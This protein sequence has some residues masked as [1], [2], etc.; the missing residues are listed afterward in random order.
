M[1]AGA[2]FD[3]R[4]R[5]PA[6]A[7]PTLVVTGEEDALIPVINGEAIALLI[8]GARYACL[9]GSGH[10]LAVERPAE[11]ALLLDELLAENRDGNDCNGVA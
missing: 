5:L 3:V 9:P 6:L 1:R 10:M 11:L 7:L 8:P 2:G 4:N